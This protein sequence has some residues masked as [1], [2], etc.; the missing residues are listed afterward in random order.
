MKNIILGI[1]GSI[2]AYKSAELVRQL[3][4]QGAEVRV[5]MTE[6]AQAFI[7]PLTLQAL[8]G[9]AVLSSW[10]A[11]E[12]DAGMDHIALARWADV[13]ICA[14]A[15]ANFIARLVHGMADDLLTTL[16]LATSAPVI[17][18]P[19]MNPHMWAHIATQTNI[20]LLQQRGVKILGPAVGDH[21]CGDEGLGRMLEPSQIA[22]EVLSPVNSALTGQRILITAGP[23]H[24]ALDPV[25]YLTNHSSGKMG[26][27]LAEAALA[28]GADVTLITG[29][30]ALTCNPKIKRVNVVSAQDMLNAVM[31]SIPQTT[32]FISAAAVAD[33]QSHEIAAHKLKKSTTEL[34]L[35][36]VRTPDILQAV[37]QLKNK[38]FT[39]GFALETENLLENAQKKLREKKLD[40]IIAN[41][42]GNTTGFNADTNAV[43]ILYANGQ[44]EE[45]SLMTKNLL[46]QELMSRISAQLSTR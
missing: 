12:T 44:Q 5:V 31:A 21:A 8:S 29:P 3:K 40:M 37:A 46:A 14:P 28:A 18:A 23:T 22:Q 19:A 7:T 1:S 33:Y 13:V 26:F 42:T 39:I 16:C 41:Q 17:I 43:N 38:P 20:K 34:Q 25:R 4:Q 2:A 24:E 36:L 45:M 27:A 11:A 32:I 9:N 30:V 35:D 6:H 15:S 10:S